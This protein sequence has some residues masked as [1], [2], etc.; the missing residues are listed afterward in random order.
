MLLLDKGLGG[1]IS[2]SETGFFLIIYG[3]LSNFYEV[4]NLKIIF[5]SQV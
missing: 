5:Y 1:G 4:Y 3:K 2:F